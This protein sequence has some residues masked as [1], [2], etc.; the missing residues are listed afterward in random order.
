[1]KL[2]DVKGYFN[3][4]DIIESKYKF[5][6]VTGARGIGK[7][8]STIK[9]LLE[10][11]KPF[12]YLRRTQ[13]ESDLQANENT[14]S[15][16]KVLHALKLE[17]VFKKLSKKVGVV[18]IDGVPMI[19]TC[20]LSTFASIRGINFDNVNYAVYDEFITEPHVRTFK[21]EGMAL[22]NFYE[23]VNRNREL[24]NMDALTLVCLSNSLNI[25]NDIFM[26][27][28]LI[29][30]AER[31]TST[32]VEEFTRGDILLL[33]LQNSPISKLKSKT[34]LY[35]NSSEEYSRMA[36]NNDFILNDFSYVKKRNIKEYKIIFNVGDLYLY[37]HKSRNEYYVTFTK[38]NTKRKYTSSINDLEK[39]RRCENKYFGKYL[40]GMIRF[41]S[42]KAVVLFEKYYN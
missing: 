3:A 16:T 19:Y 15:I 9:Y 20:A 18:L 8:Y 2:Y 27:F 31:L 39:F 11:K 37:K 1:M 34:V 26:E 21:A 6:F 35:N 22:M 24:E 33:I 13:D 4:K 12:I 25:A 28:N 32:G 5:I 36:I 29:T 42:Y 41:D 23:S 30:D 7:T 10:C 38:S 14:S 40:D 17:Y